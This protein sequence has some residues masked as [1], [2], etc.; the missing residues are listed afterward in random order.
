MTNKQL[1]KGLKIK[2]SYDNLVSF[3]IMID[4]YAKE[5]ATASEIFNS[6]LNI[7][8]IPSNYRKEITDNVIN[9][10]QKYCFDKEL[11]LNEKFK[12]I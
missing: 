9:F 5:P 3:R 4:T 8:K 12:E 1:E 7:N 2:K 10:I 6:T 11:E